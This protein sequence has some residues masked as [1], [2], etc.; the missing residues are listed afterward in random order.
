MRQAGILAAAGLHAVR[1]HVARLA[2]DHARAQRLAAG[3]ADAAPGVTDP[4]TVETNIVV[5]DL[6]AAAVDAAGLATACGAAGVLVST[7]APRRVRLVTHLDID[8]DGVDR[9]LAAIRTALRP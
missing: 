4:A 3:I 9:A 8:D 1:N 2:D 7:L 5:L 6:A